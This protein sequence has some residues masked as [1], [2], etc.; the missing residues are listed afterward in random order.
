MF[1]DKTTGSYPCT[2]CGKIFSYEYYREK[3]LKYTRCVDMGDRKFPCPQCQRSFEKK[4]RLRI[5]ILHVHQKYR[6]HVCKMC[7]KRF[8]QSSSLNKHSRV[9]TGE[10]P[11]SCPHCPKSFTASSILRTHLRQH[12]GERPFKCKFCG[13]AFASH[14]AHDSHVKRTHDDL[15]TCFCKVC[16]KSFSVEFELKFHLSIHSTEQLAN[17]KENYEVDLNNNNIE[18]IMTYSD[19]SENS[20]EV[21]I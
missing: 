15:K 2:R 8:S 14:A 12:N 16:G 13:K 11:Y 7:G 3:H 17:V 4:E 6:P 1:L 5:H 20:L 9:H 19:G 18:E 21:E 10:R